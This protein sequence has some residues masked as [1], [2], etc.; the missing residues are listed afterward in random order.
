MTAVTS[1]K[2]P[3]PVP[4]ALWASGMLVLAVALLSSSP[5]SPIARRHLRR[6]GH[7]IPYRHRRLRG[8]R[9]KARPLP[10]SFGPT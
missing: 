8:R 7:P 9:R 1:A 5:C 3:G 10:K 4:G 6:G 2:P